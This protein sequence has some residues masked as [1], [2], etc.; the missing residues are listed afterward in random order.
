MRHI[1]L[2]LALVLAVNLSYSQRKTP[3]KKTALKTSVAKRPTIPRK[4][5]LKK[6]VRKPSILVPYRDKNLWG[7]SDTLGNV[8]VLPVY[9][10][11]IKIHYYRNGQANFVMKGD[12]NLVVVNQDGRVVLPESVSANYDSISVHDYYPNHVHVHKN[13]K[14]GIYKDGGEIVPAIYHAVGSEPNDSFVV[15][16]DNLQGLYNGAGRL[17]IPV[18]YSSIDLVW[19]ES[20]DDKIVWHAKTAWEEKKFTDVRVP[21]PY[22]APYELAEKRLAGEE[23]I[24]DAAIAQRIQSQYD[25]VTAAPYYGIYY[26]TRGGLMGVYDGTADKEIIAPQYESIS[27]VSVEKNKKIYGVR[28][29]GKLGMVGNDNSIVVPIEFDKITA[30]RYLEGFVLVKDGKKGFYVRNTAYPYIKPLYNE[31]IEK[32]KIPVSRKWSFE[33]FKVKTDGGEGYVGENGVEFFRD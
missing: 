19:E 14:L 8:R 11:L 29:Q 4:P 12:K 20:T 15:V 27:L 3:A 32:T 24:V 2:L 31:F 7:F 33:L 23:V 30:D 1:T 13:G 10:K 21:Q 18:K 5:P 16:D 22:D 28:H 17:I 26:V 25:K 9:K 6:S